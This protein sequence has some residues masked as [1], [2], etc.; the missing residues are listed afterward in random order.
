LTAGPDR[1]LL[2]ACGP[3]LLALDVLARAAGLDVA[4]A[5]A[6]ALRLELAGAVE[7][8]PGDR[9]RRGGR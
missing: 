8:A 3:R 2:A 4:A 5:A 6:A 1:L 7:R 9:Y